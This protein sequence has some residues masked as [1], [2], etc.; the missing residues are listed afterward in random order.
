MTEAEVPER[1]L[2]R[3]IVDYPLVAM[4]IAV[5]VYIAAVALSVVLGK[6]VPPIGRTAVSAI[7]A[8]I[9]IGLLLIAYKLVIVRL[10]WR[11]KDDLT[12]GPALKQAGIGL[13]IGFALM[14]AAVAAAAGLGVYR[15]NGPGD[16]SM[17]LMAL[18]TSA[19]IPGFT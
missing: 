7:H 3:R 5:V 11:P 1:P 18:I 8:A 16:S 13:G 6:F 14:A 10:G 4:L 15:I 19:I 9:A 17:L 12:A 2:W